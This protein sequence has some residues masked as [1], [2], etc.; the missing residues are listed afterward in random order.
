MEFIHH[1]SDKKLE[2]ELRKIVN[3]LSVALAEI[4]GGYGHIG[5]MHLEEL[6]EL[7]N[8]YNLKAGTFSGFVLPG[9]TLLGAKAHVIR[10]ICR[11]AERAYAKV[12]EKY[13]TSEIIFEYLNKLSSLF[14]AVARIFD[15]K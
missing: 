14:F 5:T 4:A 6:I 7:V 10:T 11:R 2:M 1:I 13:K 12:Y 3:V 8:D 15:E 9:E